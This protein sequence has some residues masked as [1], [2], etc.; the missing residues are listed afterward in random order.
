L[1]SP[2]RFFVFVV[3]WGSVAKPTSTHLS[4]FQL[5]NS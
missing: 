3:W 5:V 2:T 4:R 1:A